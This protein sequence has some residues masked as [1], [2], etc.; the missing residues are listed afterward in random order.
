MLLVRV[1]GNTASGKRATTGLSLPVSRRGLP[2]DARLLEALSPW[3][4]HDYFSEAQTWWNT[5]PT[6]PL[7][8]VND[9]DSGSTTG[10]S[11]SSH[12]KI[13][14][15]HSVADI[16]RT[17]CGV[18]ERC[19]SSFVLHRLVSMMI[20][21]NRAIVLWYFALCIIR[22]FISQ[23]R[24]RVLYVKICLLK[25]TFDVQWCAIWVHAELTSLDA[26]IQQ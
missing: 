14:R 17:S 18:T 25:K 9:D 13:K 20:W 3:P 12:V 7:G 26:Y 19:R 23:R 8:I 2:T 16:H 24:I 22:I 10:E 6:K 4:H 1:P 21:H 11:S 15:L 5:A